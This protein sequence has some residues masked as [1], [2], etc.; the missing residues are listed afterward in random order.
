MSQPFIS[1]DNIDFDHHWRD[2]QAGTPDFK[3]TEAFDYFKEF[4]PSVPFAVLDLGCGFGR[5][6]PI[7]QDVGAVYVGI[8]ASPE[9]IKAAKERHPDDDDTEFYLLRAQDLDAQRIFDVVF[10]HAFLQHTNLESKRRIFPRVHDALKPRGLFIYQ[11]KNDG[12]GATFFT[13]EG[14]IRFTELFGFKLLKSTGANT[15]ENGFVFRKT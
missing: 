3:G 9:A 15:R 7:W 12:E 8:D 10:C 13:E 4:L 1:D 14:W 11:E 6:V 2:E 5:W